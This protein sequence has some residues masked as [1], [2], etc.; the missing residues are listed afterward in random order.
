MLPSARSTTKLQP[1]VPL[2]M[3]PGQVR[4][5]YVTPSTS[6]N[7]SRM[8]RPRSELVFMVHLPSCYRPSKTP[9]PPARPSA[10]PRDA[11]PGPTAACPGPGRT[12]PSAG[13]ARRPWRS[14]SRAAAPR[15]G[16][17]AGGNATSRVTVRPSRR[18]PLG[19]RAVAALPVQDG[20]GRVGDD[21]PPPQA[22]LA[23][24]RADRLAAALV[25]AIM[26]AAFSPALHGPPPSS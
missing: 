6:T 26:P 11:A 5:V 13:A 16:G 2:T 12:R 10:P 25:E 22:P 21:L 9:R 18:P 23:A 19:V 24:L 1:R 7:F 14:A 17:A 4:T 8:V 15:S 3:S 20:P